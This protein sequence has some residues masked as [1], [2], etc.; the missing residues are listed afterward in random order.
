MTPEQGIAQVRA[1][2]RRAWLRVPLLVGNEAVN[3]SLDNFRL[4]G[5]QGASFIKWPARKV[6][7]VKDKRP[8]R[9][10]LINTGALRRSIRI[11]RLSSEGVTVGSDVKYARA[12]NEGY[13]MG[14]IQTVKGF[15]R[16]RTYTDEVSAPRARTAKFQKIVIGQ[17]QVKSHTRRVDVRIPRRQFLGNSPYL[18][19]RIK[20]VVTLACIREIK[21]L[22]P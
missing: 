2:F 12:H 7:W 6:G 14:H 8:G 18:D 16:N 19:A 3:F 22:Q 4:Q 10:L 20:R 9:A 11:V 17:S 5:F 21:T 13:R 1:G 15:T